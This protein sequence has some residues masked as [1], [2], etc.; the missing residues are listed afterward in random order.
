MG[1]RF[2]K[3]VSV[4]KGLRVGVS[5]S[6]VCLSFGAK[7]ARDSIHSSGRT[8]RTGANTREASASHYW[9]PTR[10]RRALDKLLGLVKPAVLDRRL[11]HRVHT[12]GVMFALRRK[13]L[14]GS[15]FFLRAASRS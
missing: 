6:G 3:C 5:N 14:V 2:C 10:L 4:G 9:M 12:V 7:G 15:Y 11:V 8:R 1:F 13:K